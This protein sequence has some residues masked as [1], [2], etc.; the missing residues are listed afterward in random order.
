MTSTIAPIVMNAVDGRQ[1]NETS[2]EERDIIALFT[3]IRDKLDGHYDRKERLVKISRDITALSKKMIFS[4]HRVNDETIPPNIQKE[5]DARE[6]EIQK[7]FEKAGQD[8]QGTNAYRYNPTF[9]Y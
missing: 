4:L 9:V 8:V 2:T 6:N 5:V 3:D 1:N 7:L